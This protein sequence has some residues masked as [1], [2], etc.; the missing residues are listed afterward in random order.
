M[1][2]NLNIKLKVKTITKTASLFCLIG[3]AGAL[4]GCG[5]KDN[6]LPPT[7]LT[8]YTPKI[9][10][11][12]KWSNS[13]RSGSKS[14]AY[15]IGTTHTNN[16]L[17]AASMSGKLKAINPLN[18]STLWS[19]STKFRFSATP[20]IEYQTVY[21]GT[22]DGYLTAFDAVNGTLKWKANIGSTVLAQAE[23]HNST[24]FVHS[25]N[26]ALTAVNAKDGKVLW[27]Y[28][29]IIPT[30]QISQ[31]IKTKAILVKFQW[32]KAL[33]ISKDYFLHKPK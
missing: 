28:K 9:K 15:V 13:V 32:M 21:I 1:N 17:I 25:N 29:D 5:S 11:K 18:G 14:N 3:L 33:F 7:P 30:I 16:R 27:S 31:L 2:L 19:K 20:L 12:K 6:T 8:K 26:D 10:I 22:Y 24:V 23:Y 4:T